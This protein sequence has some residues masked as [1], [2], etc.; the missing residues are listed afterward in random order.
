MPSLEGDRISVQLW[1]GIILEH[2]HPGRDRIDRPL[3]G[4]LDFSRCNC[5]SAFDFT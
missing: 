3:T 4:S 2:L 5:N 1:G